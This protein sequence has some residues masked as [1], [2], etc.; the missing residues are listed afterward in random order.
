MPGLPGR[1]EDVCFLAGL[2]VFN[3]LF[4]YVFMGVLYIIILI[5]SRL[6]LSY[7]EGKAGYKF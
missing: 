7:G 2:F 6:E 5:I 1:P 4:S 3:V